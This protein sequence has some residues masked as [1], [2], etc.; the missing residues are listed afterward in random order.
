MGYNVRALLE[1]KL[2]RNTKFWDGLTKQLPKYLE[3]EDVQIGYFIVIMFN[4]ADH[5]RTT[6]IIEKVQ[7]VKRTTGQDIRHVLVDAGANPPSA[8]KL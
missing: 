3:A 4:D 7:E 6:G 8:S 1:L 2:A 5:E